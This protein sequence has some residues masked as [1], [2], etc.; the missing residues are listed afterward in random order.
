MF[1][2]NRVTGYWNELTNSHLNAKNIASFKAGLD[3]LPILAAKA[4]QFQFIKAYQTQCLLLTFS[5]LLKNYLS[6]TNELNYLSKN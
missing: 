5:L 6:L 1:Y 3:S 4:Y 2:I